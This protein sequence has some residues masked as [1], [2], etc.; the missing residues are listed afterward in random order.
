GV[1][2]NED[3]GIKLKTIQL[4]QLGQAESIII[5]KSNVDFEREKLQNRLASLV[6]GVAVIK[7]GA[8]TDV[9]R[10]E[11]KDRL[12]D[13]IQATRAALQEGVVPGGGESENPNFGYNAAT[14][15]FEDLVES[16]VI[17]PTKVTRT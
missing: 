3:L 7:I 2:L 9:E 8:S 15:T 17:D 10:R 16:G 4:E 14:D 6:G 11:K 5:D 13:A 1:V 12:E